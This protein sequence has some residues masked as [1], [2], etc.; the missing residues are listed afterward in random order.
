[1]ELARFSEGTICALRDSL[2]EAAAVN[3]PVDV[4]GDANA[5]RYAVALGAVLDD[6]Q[7]DGVVVILTPQVLT[8]V[9]GT[10]QTIVDATGGRGKP[11]LGCFMGEE[12]TGPGAEL[13]NRG[14][15]PNYRSPERVVSALRAMWDYARYRRRKETD[16]QS[17]TVDRKR[18]RQILDEALDEGSPTTLVEAQAREVIAAYGIPIPKAWLARTSEEA[19]EMAQEIGFPV[20]LKVASPDILHKS[21]VGGIALN[22][23][24]VE[25]VRRAYDSIRSRARQHVP[26]ADVWG[27]LV[28]E[29][30][31][32]GKEVIIGMNRDAQFG[33]LLM[34]GLGGIY[35]E[36]LEDV[37]FRLAPV[38]GQE[39]REM[40]GEIQAAP[41]LH[42]IRGEG[43]VDLEAVVE[44]IQ[45]VS[46]LA[47]DF[48]EIIE[49]DLNPTVVHRQG[50]VA[51]DARLS[52]KAP[53]KHR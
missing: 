39:A 5:D 16:P 38:T 6:P 7:V 8:D 32:P 26:A 14:R 27:V 40:I 31:E 42:G 33:P 13:L 37:T 21:D 1:M 9:E 3:N 4:L 30:V 46:Q 43:P 44:T 17:F 41:L 51:L 49:L 52:L 23:G 20:V 12:T 22:L 19:V 2:P 48:P 18:V 25:E 36:V 53:D 29:M 35:V 10:A 28:Q 47:T 34:F 50:A 11:V 45:R 24:S 15:I